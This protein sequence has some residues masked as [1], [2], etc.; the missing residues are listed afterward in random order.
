MEVTFMDFAAVCERVIK[1]IRSSR[2][3]FENYDE[4]EIN[5]LINE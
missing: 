3:L 2:Y 4:D 1:R 5:S